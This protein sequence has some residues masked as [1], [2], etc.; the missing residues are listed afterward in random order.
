[1]NHLLSLILFTP[2]VG[3]AVL[4]FVNKRNEDA[5]RWIA[6]LFGLAGFLVS[7]PLWFYYDYTNPSWQFVEKAEWIPAIGAQYHL[8]VDGF[9]VLLLLLTTLMGAIAILSSWN[10][11]KERVKEY[12]IFLLIL[13]TGMIGAFVSLDF[14]LFFLFWEVMLVPMY[15]LIGIWG[16]DR[17]LYSAI[18]FFL[19]TLVG[20]VVMLLGILALYYNYTDPATGQRTFDIT[21]FQ[22]H[23]FDTNLQW[24][25]FLAFFLGFSIKVP[26]FPFHTWLPDAH[27]DAPTAGSV[28][29]AAV[30]LKMGTYGFIRFSL[31]ILPDATQKAVWWIAALSIIGIVYGA[32]VA[33]AQRDWKRLVAYSSVSHM[34]LVMLG[35]FALNPVGIKG[36]IIQQINHGIS[37]GALFLL[38]GVVYERRHTRQISEYGGLSKVMPVYAAIFCV[39]MLSSIGLPALNGFIGEFLILQGIFTVNKMWAAF[40]ASGIVLGAAYMLWLYQRTMFGKI[41]NPKNEAL[42]DMSLREVMTFVPLIILAVWIGIYPTPFLNRLNTSVDRVVARVS[43]QYLPQSASAADC[44]K[45]PAPS[46]WQV[47]PCGPEEAAKTAAAPEGTV[48][49]AAPTHAAAPAAP[50]ADVAT[51]PGEAA[52]PPAPAGKTAGGR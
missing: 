48:P 31:P 2:L 11:I 32:L 42:Q 38:V 34:A 9:A 27:T 28:I 30:L 18:K 25:V 4:M 39:M 21:Q 41:E 16:S 49:A 15:F 6:N 8:G 46:K 1:M 7:L 22:Q 24:W 12:Y 14:L 5:I 40:A 52:K 20:S 29:L 45:K 17:R 33:M 50:A 23:G 44:D 36:S 10:A 43:P 26:M 51:P 19:Y 3:A 13:Q 37:T 35:M 47:A